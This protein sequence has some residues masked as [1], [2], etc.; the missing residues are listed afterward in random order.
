MFVKMFNMAHNGYTFVIIFGKSQIIYF[1]RA[2]IIIILYY[3]ITYN[4]QDD[5]RHLGISN[6]SHPVRYYNIMS[7]PIMVIIQLLTINL[8]FPP[9]TKASLAR[10]YYSL[11][12]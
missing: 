12:Q 8:K 6:F 11:T 2:R 1:V 4:K 7:I 3:V 5:Y 9:C 10:I